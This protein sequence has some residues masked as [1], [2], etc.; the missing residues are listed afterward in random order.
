MAEPERDP[1]F[2]RTEEGFGEDPHLG[3]QMASAYIKGM[4]G[5]NPN[6]I[7]T[8]ATLK[9]FTGYNSEDRPLRVSIDPRSF[10]E[11]YLEPYRRC[12]IEGGAEGV[13]TASNA[14]NGTPALFGDHLQEVLRK[15]WRF[16]GHIVGNECSLEE[17]CQDERFS[18]R[19]NTAALAI[20]AGVDCFADE[21]EFVEA[22]V[23]VLTTE[24]FFQ[25]RTLTRRC[26]QLCDKDSSWY[27]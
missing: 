21:P 17:L 22:A 18:D 26:A 13:M 8:A 9:Y 19:E 7:K 2:G 24:I 20:K 11:Y 12:I 25:C 14:I 16:S 10:Y 27:V 5:D 3:G 1:R 4:R 15:E 6:Y 23:A